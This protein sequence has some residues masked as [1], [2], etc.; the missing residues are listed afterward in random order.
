MKDGAARMVSLERRGSPGTQPA[1]SPEHLS[2]QSPC[3]QASEPSRLPHGIV[4]S[5]LAPRGPSMCWCASRTRRCPCTRRPPPPT[6]GWTHAPTASAHPSCAHHPSSC[7]G[8]DR[9]R[10]RRRHSCCGQW[11]SRGATAGRPPGGARY[12]GLQNRSVQTPCSARLRLCEQ[13]RQRQRKVITGLSKLVQ[14]TGDTQEC[15]SLQ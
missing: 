15:C 4:S 14:G 1:T 7:G 12:L 5:L 11:R 13:Q 2:R 8:K 10:R 3:P 6:T 9:G